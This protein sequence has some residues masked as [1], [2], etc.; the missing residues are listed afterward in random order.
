[1]MWLVLALLGAG[2]FAEF[3]VRSDSE[4]VALGLE[5]AQWT[6]LALIACAAVG[7]WVTLARRDRGRPPGSGR[8]PIAR[9]QA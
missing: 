7:A 9:N 4:T 2:R 6:S 8:P 1:M 3:F 5:V